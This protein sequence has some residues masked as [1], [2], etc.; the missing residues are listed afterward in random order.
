MANDNV[1]HTL[2]IDFSDKL[3]EISNGKLTVDVYSN[4][5]L[6]DQVELFEGMKL[7]TVD[8]SISDTSIIASYYS[9]KWDFR[10]ALFFKD[11]EHIKKLLNTAKMAEIKKQ[12]EAKSGVKILSIQ[13]VAY[14]NIILKKELADKNKFDGLNSSTKFSCTC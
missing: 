2:V 12:V 9:Q 13:P 10:Y 7:G 3:K 6:G 5:I 11:M 1:N 14:R 4:G 8:M